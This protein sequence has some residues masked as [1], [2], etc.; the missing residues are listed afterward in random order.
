MDCERARGSSTMKILF[1]FVCLKGPGSWLSLTT[2]CWNPG[3]LLAVALLLWGVGAVSSQL[4]CLRWLEIAHPALELKGDFTVPSTA[5]AW[6]ENSLQRACMA[7]V[8]YALRQ[9][10]P[11]FLTFLMHVGKKCSELAAWAGDGSRSVRCFCFAAGFPPV[12][13]A[14]FA[15]LC[16]SAAHPPQCSLGGCLCHMLALSIVLRSSG[17]I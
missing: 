2:A 6:N 7:S 3:S 11:L 5:V 16:V 13:C 15:L 8:L 17:V 12:P 1:C 14:Q 4:S 9:L 10:L